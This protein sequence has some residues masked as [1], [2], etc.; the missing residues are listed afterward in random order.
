MSRFTSGFLVRIAVGSATE[1][2]P[3]ILH[4]HVNCTWVR[5]LLAQLGDPFLV[6]T[7]SPENE[8]NVTTRY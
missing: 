6:F 3:Q 7:F 2:F 1:G 8:M 5:F 4:V